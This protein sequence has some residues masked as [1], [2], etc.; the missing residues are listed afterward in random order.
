MSVCTPLIL[1]LSHYYKHVWSKALIS[2]WTIHQ[3]SSI[4]KLLRTANRHAGAHKYLQHG[5]IYE[6]LINCQCV[7]V[8]K[9]QAYAATCFSMCTNGKLNGN[10]CPGFELTCSSPCPLLLPGK[11]SHCNLPFQNS[12]W[13]SFTLDSSGTLC[14]P[15]CYL[16]GPC[17]N[18]NLQS[19]A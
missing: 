8:S 12:L 11:D 16:C 13:S 18:F 1:S 6:K 3:W 2:N 17:N 15:W 14:T 4:G 9:F 7:N 10:S 19:K 5:H